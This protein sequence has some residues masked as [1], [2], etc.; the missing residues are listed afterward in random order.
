[1]KATIDGKEEILMRR[2]TAKRWTFVIGADGKIASKNTSVVAADDSKAI[3]EVV[4][5]LKRGN[6]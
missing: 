5:R 2:V 3:M 4:A 1:V 6:K